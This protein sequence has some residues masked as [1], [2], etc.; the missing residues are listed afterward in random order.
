[1][2]FKWKKLGKLFDPKDLTAASWMHDYAQ[3]PSVLIEDDYV[4]V[5]FCS[6]PAPGPDGLYLSYISF[7]D[8]DRTNLHNI[9]RVCEQRFWNWENTAPLT[10]SAPIRFR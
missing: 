8:L 9:L 4:R 6:R 10:N 1:M 7:I 2:T 5:Y 3:S